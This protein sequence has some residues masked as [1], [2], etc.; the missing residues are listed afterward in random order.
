MIA[1]E[2][3]QM[4]V[5][6]VATRRN[7]HAG[8]DAERRGD[9]LDARLEGVLEIGA[10]VPR[11]L[12]GHVAAPTHELAVRTVVAEDAGVRPQLT[13]AARAERLGLPERRPVVELPRHAH[14]A[15]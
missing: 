10:V 12:I 11:D 9:R 4:L 7:D 1:F 14:T 15:H 6:I 8:R 3:Q 5:P 13:D 2:P